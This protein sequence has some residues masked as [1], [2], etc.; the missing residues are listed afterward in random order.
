M[1]VASAIEAMGLCLP[2]SASTPAQ[3]DQ[4]RSECSLV[5][6][7]MLKLLEMDLKPR[8][9]ITKQ[10]LENAITLTMALGGSTNLV[11]HLLAVA[12]VAGIE[13]ELSD[14]QRISDATPLIADLK[15]R[16]LSILF[17]CSMLMTLVDVVE[18]T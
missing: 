18:S 1:V 7:T 4:K 5:G 17:L 9:L 3:S 14:F 12:R 6:P 16:Y 2:N 8:D 13:L 10:S 15:P 11:L